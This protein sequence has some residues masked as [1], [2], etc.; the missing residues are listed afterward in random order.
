MLA[1]IDGDPMLHLA[2]RKRWNAPTGTE[3][4]KLDEKG[5]REPTEFTKKQDEQ[6][7]MKSYKNFHKDLQEV[8]DKTWSNDYVMAFGH[9]NDNFRLDMYPEYKSN[10]R[11]EAAKK[12]QN[13][14]VPILKDLVLNEGLGVRS[15]YREADDMVGI[16]ATQAEQ[17][18]IPFVVCTVDKDLKCIPGKYYNVKNKE[19]ETITPLFAMRHYYGQLLQGDPTDYIPGIPGLGPKTAMGLMASCNTPEECQEIVV[20]HY[21]SYYDE[22]WEDFLLANG[23]L[24]HIQRHWNDYFTLKNWPLVQELR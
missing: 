13:P 14:F 12:H 4:V 3:F 6:Y 17:E 9:A 20:S 10:R 24:I 16:W 5:V 22:A 1:I 19:L 15:P 7:L 21:I 23:K 11:T 8:L 2:C 18:G